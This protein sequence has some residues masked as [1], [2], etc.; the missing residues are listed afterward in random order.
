MKPLDKN[1]KT[2]VGFT[3]IG[4]CLAVFLILV[5]S[6][7]ALK[8]EASD[9]E[10]F[11]PKI[12]SAHTVIVLDKTDSL[13]DN[14]QRVTADYI[15]QEIDKLGIYE[16]LSVFMLTG[17]NY[18]APEP[19]FSKCNPGN[20]EDANQL[21]QNPKKIKERFNHLFASPL[22][23]RVKESLSNNIDSQSPILEMIQEL[24]LRNDFNENIRK[25][26]LIV[27][28]DMMHHTPNY[29]HYKDRIDYKSF[30]KKAYADEVMANLHSVNV[31]IVYLLRGN[32]N[33][34]QGK[35]HLLF[36]ENYFQAMGADVVGVRNIR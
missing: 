1:K 3:I 5:I 23:K 13:N 33:R 26:T 16:K 24:S 28:S 12:I 19:I 30:S 8:E 32:L 17:N 7:F 2:K 34:L 27:I 18:V 6:A 14:Q 15:N 21:Y 10:T 4:I 25:R 35:R 9:P 11:C 36:W 20:G 22:K 31:Q 29:S